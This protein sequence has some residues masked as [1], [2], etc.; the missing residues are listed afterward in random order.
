[1]TNILLYAVSVLVWGSTW[2]V[3]NFQLG[4]VPPEVSVVW[5]YLLAA[6]LLFGWCALR[7]VRM[8]YGWR[9]HMVF[10]GLGLTLFG[11]NYIATYS[12]QQHITS[13][14]NAVAFSS[15]VWM[16]IINARLF[17][18]TRMS[19]PVIIGAALGMIG[20]V[21]VFWPELRE[22]D[23]AS[24]TIYGASLSLGGALVAS[25]GN[26]L[27]Q[28]AQ[29]RQLP[30]LASNAWGMLYGAILVALIA[31]A[32]GKPFLFEWTTRYVASLLY[33]AVFGSIVA[34][35]A[36]LTLLGR[37]GAQRA[38]Y[39]VV[40]FP[41]V[42]IVLSVLFEGLVIDDH[43]IVG[44]TLVLMGNTIILA[45]RGRPVATAAPAAA[46]AVRGEG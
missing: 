2:L 14:L 26:M 46:A 23:L 43:I 18:G 17:F 5:R 11:L 35:G 41:V 33:L 13:A 27:S 42:A 7:G 20:I 37:I 32:G 45:R 10:A 1:M 9:E 4:V 16:N 34:F 6:A 12:A 39:A 44:V 38:G 40:M 36:Y 25:L 28:R 30:V 31:A 24:G 22:L 3:I 15:M 19:G 21:V 8:S 29:S